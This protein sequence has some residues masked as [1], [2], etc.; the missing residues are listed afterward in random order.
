MQTIK[1]AAANQVY[2]I[3][4]YNQGNQSQQTVFSSAHQHIGFAAHK[5]LG[6][7]CL[8]LTISSI[9]SQ[10]QRQLCYSQYATAASVPQVPM[11][12]RS[13]CL[14]MNNN[15][16]ITSN[17]LH[18]HQHDTLKHSHPALSLASVQWIKTLNGQMNTD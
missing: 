4:L 5:S 3:A 12:T 1:G 8:E 15:L 16:L 10:Y 6:F 9:N 11:T 13:C 7:S 17:N 14:Y 18:I 2:N